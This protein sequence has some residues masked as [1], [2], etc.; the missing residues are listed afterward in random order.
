MKTKITT[1]FD[2]VY[3]NFWGLNLSEDG[4]ECESFTVISID[5]LL[6]YK[7]KYYLQVYLNNCDYKIV[8]EKL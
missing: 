6:V 8:G 3:A 4:V 1:Y 7:N 5:T 2:K